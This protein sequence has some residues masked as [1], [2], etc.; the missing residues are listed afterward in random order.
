MLEATDDSGGRARIGGDDM[1][2]LVVE[3]LRFEDRGRVLLDGVTLTLE[4]KRRTVV[5]GPNGA[6]KSLLLRML[7]GLMQPTSGAIRW[8]GRE[9]S[10]DIHAR[11][12][13]VFQRPTLLR[14]S[15]LDNLVFVLDHLPKAERAARA[16]ELLTAAKLEHVAAT[17][18]RLLSG[19]EQQRLTIA[20]ALA[21]SPDVL[22]LDEPSASL[23]PVSTLHIEEMMLACHA[24]GAKIIL[25]THDVGQA[26][27]IA[28]DVVFMSHGRVTEAGPA[29]A[30]FAN[31]QSPEARAYLAG[32]L[33]L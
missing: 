29:A 21:R 24:D 13:M 17:P 26:R 19:G 23:D 30:F 25:V 31:P 9:M 32:H 7:H 20:R 3:G 2:P 12:A 5:I 33:V 8:A 6:G 14:R 27:R 1:F 18:A 4:A 11:Q 15:A 28:E 16:R 22:F 10:P